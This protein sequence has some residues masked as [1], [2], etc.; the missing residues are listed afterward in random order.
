MMM[1]TKIITIESMLV[2]YAEVKMM[3]KIVLM[4][5]LAMEMSSYQDQVKITLKQSDTCVLF[6]E[7]AV[8]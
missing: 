8:E 4:A 5:R 6:T 3:K 7:L 1:K 2:G